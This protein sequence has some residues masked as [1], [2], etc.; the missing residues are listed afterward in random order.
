M[1]NY[2]WKA[3]RELSFWE[4][5]AHRHPTTTS[6][7]Y[8][9]AAGIMMALF[10]S[11]ALFLQYPLP[12]EQS[13]KCFGVCQVHRGISNRR[14]SHE[15][16]SLGTGHTTNPRIAHC[17]NNRRCNREPYLKVQPRDIRRVSRI[18][19]LDSTKQKEPLPQ[20]R[21][22]KEVAHEG[23]LHSVRL[24]GLCPMAQQVS[25]VRQRD[26]LQRLCR[27]IATSGVRSS[28]HPYSTSSL[29]ACQV[30]RSRLLEIGI[31]TTR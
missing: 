5:F 16:I 30:G 20:Q 15:E 6:L 24:Y 1:T 31:Q 19:S 9:A 29:F 12:C 10:I 25:V 23:L 13:S 18:E 14:C 3:K 21:L 22:R 26:G 4:D 27:A 11:K 17:G 7:A 2:G 28:P 8:G